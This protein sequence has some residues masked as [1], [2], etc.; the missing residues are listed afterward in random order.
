MALREEFEYIAFRLAAVSYP[1]LSSNTIFFHLKMLLLLLLEPSEEAEAGGSKT[2]GRGGEASR[3][4]GIL[5]VG[6]LRPKQ[7]PGLQTCERVQD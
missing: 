6:C 1:I 5:R 2:C 7:R 4:V 3:V